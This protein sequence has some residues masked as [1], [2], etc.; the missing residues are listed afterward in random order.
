MGDVSP[1]LPLIR[2]QMCP[3]LDIIFVH[4][5]VPMYL[6]NFLLRTRL[7]TIVGESQRCSDSYA[8]TKA[9]TFH[10]H[11]HHGFTNNQTW[12]LDLP[13]PSY[14]SYTLLFPF[15]PIFSPSLLL[16][17]DFTCPYPKTQATSGYPDRQGSP[18]PRFVI[19]SFHSRASEH[20]HM[21]EKRALSRR[22]CDLRPRSS[23]RHTNSPQI[24]E[25][26]PY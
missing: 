6:P 19:K 7:Q 20:S 17:C 10:N 24:D 5:S 13:F 25:T 11:H 2:G 9:S 1:K 3:V 14:F 21:S 23:I 15:S 16:F 26:T 18:R 12:C 4:Q 22:Y 8:S